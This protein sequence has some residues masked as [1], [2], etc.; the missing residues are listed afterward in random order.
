MRMGTTMSGRREVKVV[1]GVAALVLLAVVARAVVRQTNCASWQSTPVNC[2]FSDTS[3]LVNPWASAVSSACNSGL[4]P[5]CSDPSLSLGYF[6]PGESVPRDD[7]AVF[8]GRG[9]H[10]AAFVPPQPTVAP[11]ADVPPTYCLAGWIA[12]LYADQ[13]TCTSTACT[14]GFCPGRAL[15]RAEASELVGKAWNKRNCQTSTPSGTGYFSDVPTGAYAVGWI[16]FVNKPVTG[17][18]AGCLSVVGSTFSPSALVTRAET[19]CLLAD[20]FAGTPL[21]CSTPTPTPT[22]APTVTFTPTKTPTVTPTITATPT[23]TPTITPTVTFTPTKTPTVTPTI[24]ATPTKTP[25]ITPTV[26][27]TPTK[28]PTVTP[29]ITATPTKTPTITPT[30]TPTNTPTKTPTR[31]PTPT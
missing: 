7:M 18:A 8:L 31:T 23:K 1:I 6:C 21:G 25:T 9:L 26:T 15:T 16:E 28:T 20:I 24:T 30:I 13:I 4:M 5:G 11:A 19:A 29:T 2:G 3:G 14:T 17:V 27:F 10:G 22:I 12:Q